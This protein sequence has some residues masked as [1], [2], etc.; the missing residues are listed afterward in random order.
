MAKKKVGLLKWGFKAE[1]NRKSISIRQDMGL[2][3]HDKL[4]GFELAAK[5]DVSVFNLNDFGYSD[6]KSSRYSDWSALTVE[7]E[8][9]NRIIIHN[10]THSSKRQQSNIMHELAHIVLG[11]KREEKHED[12]ILPL[13]RDFNPIQEAEANCLGGCLQLPKESLLWSLKKGMSHAD[14]A[15][16]FEASIQ[17]VTKRI[18]ESGAQKQMDYRARKYG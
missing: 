17:M 11:H 4:C 3:P 9:G 14:I 16:H 8:I 6:S 12:I 18:N 1:A 2:N 7:N 10:Q 5:L 15:D 13:L